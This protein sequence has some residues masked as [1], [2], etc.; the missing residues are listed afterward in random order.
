MATQ[1]DIQYIR[2]RLDDLANKV[3]KYV[4]DPDDGVFGKLGEI[5]KAGELHIQEDKQHFEALK[6]AVQDLRKKQTLLISAMGGLG[7]AGGIWTAY[8][9]LLEL[10]KTWFS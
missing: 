1:D 8:P 6:A 4:L 3:E 7:G 2:E 10:L 5:E 9:H